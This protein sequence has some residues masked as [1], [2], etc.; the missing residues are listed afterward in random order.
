M[1]RPRL[2][3]L[4]PS[5][6]TPLKLVVPVLVFSTVTVVV[7]PVVAAPVTEEEIV[8]AAAE[9][10]VQICDAPGIN[11]AGF[12]VTPLALASLMPPLP[13]ASEYVASVMLTAPIV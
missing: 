9:L 5:P 1:V 2:P 10:F 4:G 11:V 12:K 13:I 3:P 7:L 8:R 6:M